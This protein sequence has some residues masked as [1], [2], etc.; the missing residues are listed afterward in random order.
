[1]A[2]PLLCETVTGRTMDEVRRARDSSAADMVEVRLDGVTRPDGFGAIEGRR[3][4]VIVT[5]RPIWEG[6]LFDG[7]EEERHRLLGDAFRGGAEFVDVEAQAPFVPEIARMRRGD[8][9]LV[10]SRHFFGEAPPGNLAELASAMHAKGAEVVKLAF[11]AR[12]LVDLLPLMTLA[13]T[14]SRNESGEA[15]GHVLIAMGAPGVTSRILSR[16]LHNRWSYAGDGVAPGQVPLQRMVDE[17][18]V[19][20]IAAD[21]DLYGVVGNPVMHS[22][23]PAMHN[24]GFAALGMNAAYLP[25]EAA[26]LEDF[27]A[28]AGSM[29]LRGASVTAPFKVDMLQ[30][31]H[32]LDPVARQIGAVN[33]ITMR[34]GQW[35][36]ANTDVEGFLAPLSGRLRLKGTR[37]SLLG[38]GGAARA[39]AAALAREGAQ[40]TVCARRP[41]A[42]AKV[43]ALAHGRVSRIPPAAGSWD[44]LINTTSCGSA[45]QPGNLMAG[46]PLTG[47]IVFDLVYAPADTALL[48][49]A[50]AEGCLTIGGLEMLV[51]QAERQFEIWTGQRPP[52]GL[53]LAAADS[54]L[55]ATAP[56]AEAHTL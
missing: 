1:M 44:V 54:A 49:H 3:R 40:V 24:A 35:E 38:A 34:D 33:T 45:A 25:L 43:A 30:H 50:R 47:E 31:V 42:A 29:H 41:E 16:R 32:V 13:D 12:R 2:E 51:A 11:E 15:A 9:G 46:E 27:V 4:P 6:G 28:F 5:C 7:A 55:R 19:R 36:G 10:L 20:R 8:R 23:S 56:K 53:F 48:Q 52:G 37:A 22:L 17:F 18:H 14:L 21:A 26:T 39:V